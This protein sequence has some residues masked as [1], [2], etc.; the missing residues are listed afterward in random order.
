M[1]MTDAQK[2]GRGLSDRTLNRLIVGAIVALVIIIPLVGVVYF[3]DRS[4]DPGPSMAQRAVAAAEEAVR[5]Q[6]NNVNARPGARDQLPPEL[7]RYQAHVNQYGEVLKVV[8]D[9]RGALLGRGQR[10]PPHGRPGERDEGLRAPS[11]R[12]PPDR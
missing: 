11:S 7:H 2:G 9:H 1:Q 10:L 4:T 8:E 5:A 6:P 12:S 3:L